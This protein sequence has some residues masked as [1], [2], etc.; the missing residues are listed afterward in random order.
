MPSFMDNLLRQ[1]ESIKSQ[2]LFFLPTSEGRR[3]SVAPATS[4]PSRPSCWSMTP[5]AATATRA[6]LGPEDVSYDDSARI[7]SEVLG[8]SV[9][10][11][12]ISGEAF[13]AR[14]IERGMSEAMAQGNLDTWLA[15]ERGLDNAEPRTPE[16]TTATGFRDWRDDLLKPAILGPAG[17][18]SLSAGALP[19]G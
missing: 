2:G 5:G 17:P 6:V 18:P 13:K 11:Q 16:S 14:L 15:K 19:S 1:V 10:L 7:M 9:R 4:P 3:P 8:T 12:P